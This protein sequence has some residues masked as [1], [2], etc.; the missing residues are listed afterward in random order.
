MEE[1]VDNDKGVGADDEVWRDQIESLLTEY[2]RE[3]VRGRIHDMP[4]W[5]E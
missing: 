4:R 1:T 2:A 3:S 5:A